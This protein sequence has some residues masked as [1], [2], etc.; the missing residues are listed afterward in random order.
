MRFGLLVSGAIV[1]LPGIT[2]QPAVLCD[3]DLLLQSTRFGCSVASLA[4][5]IT[6]DGTAMFSSALW[7]GCV[8]AAACADISV[9]NHISFLCCVPSFGF[10]ARAWPPGSGAAGHLLMHAAAS[11]TG[12]RLLRVFSTDWHASLLPL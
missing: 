11:C 2:V 10:P 8:H 9:C 7:G 6:C 3:V 4:I 5:V 12:V 1:S